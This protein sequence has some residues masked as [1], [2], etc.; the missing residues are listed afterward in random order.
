MKCS[1]ATILL[2]ELVEGKLTSLEKEAIEKHL[3]QCDKCRTD[4]TSMS[5]V[6]Q[7]KSAIPV[8]DVPTHYFNNFLPHVKEKIESGNRRK[9]FLIPEFLE[10][11]FAPTAAAFVVA[12]FVLSFI[13]FAPRTAPLPL[14]EMVQGGSEDE[15]STLVTNSVRSPMVDRESQA[16]EKMLETISNSQSVIRKIRKDFFGDESTLYNHSDTF[17]NIENTLAELDDEELQSVVQQLQL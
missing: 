8:N 4:Y 2:M 10:K 7:L 9:N 5:A 1:N 11:I 16:N 3:A 17:L 15:I 14:R 13:L 12:A 6:V